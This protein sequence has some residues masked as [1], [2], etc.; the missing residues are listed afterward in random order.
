MTVA[1]HLPDKKRKRPQLVFGLGKEKDYII[2]NLSLLIGAGLDVLT[3]LTLLKSDIR[4]SAMRHALDG[5]INDIDNGLS[6]SEALEDSG[7]FPLY[8]VTVIRIGEGS[9]R[10]EE[11]LK[12]VALQD[13]RDRSFRSQVRSAMMYPL[14]VFS[15]TLIIGIGIAWFI[16]PRLA[17]VFGGLHLKLPWITRALMGLGQWLGIH[18]ATAVPLLLL[19]SMT[20]FYFAFF[21][22][23]TKFIGQWFLFRVPGI[24]KLLQELELSRFGY[25]LGTLLNAGIPITTAVNSLVQASSFHS[26]R[27]LYTHLQVQLEEGNSVQKS[28]ASYPHSTRLIPSPVQ[29]VIAAGEQ[30]GTMATALLRLG[31]NFSAKTEA[32]AKNLTTL[33]EPLLL[34]IVWLGVMGVALAVFLPIYNLVGGLDQ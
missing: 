12:V 32:T 15:F 3:A 20:I 21:F 11:N 16:L 5:I 13:E 19:A 23:P 27:K 1:T 30:S 26:Y 33:L 10:L 28:L 34:I 14:F 25:L 24:K 4:S 29:G 22:S 7:L 9:G 31:Q 2:E 17:T 18:G 6:L 8:M